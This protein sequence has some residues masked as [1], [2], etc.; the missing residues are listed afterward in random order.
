LNEQLD[1]IIAELKKN[2]EMNVNNKFSK[3]NVWESYAI[4]LF[5]N[6]TQ[7]EENMSYSFAG[8]AIETVTK[9]FTLLVDSLYDDVI[10]INAVLGS[11]GN[12]L[13]KSF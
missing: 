9:I 5:H 4:D 10:R 11:R 2:I 3:Q 1:N 13:C 12:I 8:Q 7:R 6:F